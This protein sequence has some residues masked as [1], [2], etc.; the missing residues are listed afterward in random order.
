MAESLISV[1]IVLTEEELTRDF[2][3][4]L[5]RRDLKEFFFYWLPISVQAWLSLCTDGAYKNFWRSRTLLQHH[6]YEMIEA[7]PWDL[8]EVVSLGSGQGI[9]DRA[10]MEAL[11]TR[12]P[13]V[14]YRPV[15]ASQSLLELALRE[16]SSMGIPT[17]GLKADISKPEQLYC[18]L[19]AAAG[20]PRLVLLLGNTLGAFDPLQYC[21]GLRLLLRK[22]DYLLIDGEIFDPASTLAGYD[23]PQNRRFAMGPLM[24]VGISEEVGTL[25]FET[26]TDERLPGL[27]RLQKHFEFLQPCRVLVAGNFIEFSPSER[28]RMNF[29]YKYSMQSF[30]E[31]VCKRAGMVPLKRFLSADLNFTMFLAQAPTS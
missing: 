31:L 1:D 23:N 5:R 29:S 3:E 26:V 25:V 21:Q 6:L 7:L 14:V 18:C 12:N 13:T 30:E 24:S 4:S 2:T 11:R 9:K 27:Y 16:M 20:G 22:G 8:A 28:V 17:R 15:D 10:L 19:G